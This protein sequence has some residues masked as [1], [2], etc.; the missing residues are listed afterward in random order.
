MFVL[1]FWVGEGEEGGSAHCSSN[2]HNESQ[3]QI[4]VTAGLILC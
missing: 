4:F 2:M 1:G 3:E